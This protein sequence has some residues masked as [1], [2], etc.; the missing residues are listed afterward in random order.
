MSLVKSYRNG[1]YRVQI[2]TETGSKYF[3]GDDLSGPDFPDSIDLKITDHC[4]CGCPFCYEGS[5]PKGQ[6]ASTRIIREIFSCLPEEPIEVAIGG[7][8]PLDHIDLDEIIDFLTGRG[9][10]VNMTVSAYDIGRNIPKSD[11]ISGLGVSLGSLDPEHIPYI[12]EESKVWK[13]TVWHAIAGVTPLET[14]TELLDRGDRVLVLGYKNMG[15]GRRE[16]IPDLRPYEIFFKSRIHS[17]KPGIMSFDELGVQQLRLSGTLMQNQWDLIW[18]GPEFSH[19]MFI[20]AVAGKFY[21]SST[22][23]EHGVSWETQTVLSYFK[24]N[25]VKDINRNR[26]IAGISEV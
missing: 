18:L 4:L 14:V 19:S 7:G 15:R 2:N 6:H 22:E 10:I 13:Q 23:R 9:H 24:K 25:H 11:K 12:P 16:V 5:S 26:Q 17:G 21:P 3:F 8:D 20:D 1:T